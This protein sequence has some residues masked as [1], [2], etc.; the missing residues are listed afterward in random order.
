MPVLCIFLASGAAVARL[1]PCGPGPPRRQR[2][3][4]EG[5]EMKAGARVVGRHRKR[6][7]NRM[8]AQGSPEKGPSLGCLE[9]PGCGHGALGW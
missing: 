2:G 4:V 3:E 1:G 6:K 9:S 8:V 5:E 7:W